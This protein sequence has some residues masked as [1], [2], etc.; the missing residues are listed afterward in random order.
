MDRLTNYP[1]LI[2]WP[3]TGANAVTS[4]ASSEGPAK[5]AHQ[6]SLEISTSLATLALTDVDYERSCACLLRCS[7]GCGS[8]EAAVEEEA[9][10]VKSPSKDPVFGNLQKFPMVLGHLAAGEC[11]TEVFG[12]VEEKCGAFL[13]L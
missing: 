1:V 11:A 3:L 7:E 6:L 4:G 12:V 9:D 13:L 8:S 5:G 2:R 10:E